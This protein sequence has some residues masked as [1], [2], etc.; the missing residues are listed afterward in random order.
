MTFC[1]KQHRDPLPA[2]RK[3]N[4]D[5]PEISFQ[6]LT[7]IVGQRNKCFPLLFAVSFDVSAN[8]VVTALVAVFIPEP[9][10]NL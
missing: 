1:G 10:I 6:T 9:S 2:I 8:L 7:G 3:I 4:I 5:V